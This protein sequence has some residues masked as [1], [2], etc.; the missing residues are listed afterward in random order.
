MATMQ[1]QINDLTI[2]VK[3]LVTQVTYLKNNTR[4]KTNNETDNEQSAHNTGNMI[5][6]TTD[7]D[8]NTIDPSRN[9]EEEVPTPMS[10]DRS[11]SPNKR[12]LE[13]TKNGNN[14]LI[15][16]M[17]PD[18]K[19]DMERYSNKVVGTTNPNNQDL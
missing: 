17:D 16:T 13:V 3:A 2:T 11:S 14:K 18:N 8:G 1:Q 5:K 4:L 15:R 10:T 9:V 6:S 12:T 7:I 19:E